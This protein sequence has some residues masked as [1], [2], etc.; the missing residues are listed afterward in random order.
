MRR[1]QGID[2]KVIV[3]IG[4]LSIMFGWDLYCSLGGN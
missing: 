3:V 4:A 1:N 2:I